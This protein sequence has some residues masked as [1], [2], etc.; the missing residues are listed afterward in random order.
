MQYTFVEWFLYYCYSSG[1][2]FPEF[3]NYKTKRCCTLHY[4]V[5]WPSVENYHI[6]LVIPLWT[7]IQRKKCGYI[8]NPPR[9]APKYFLKSYPAEQN[10]PGKPPMERNE[11]NYYLKI[12]RL[13]S[14]IDFHRQPLVWTPRRNQ[15]SELRNWTRCRNPRSNPSLESLTWNPSEIYGCAVWLLGLKAQ[16]AIRGLIMKNCVGELRMLPNFFHLFWCFFSFSQ[17]V[18]AGD[19]KGGRGGWCSIVLDQVAYSKQRTK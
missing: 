8:W 1:F 14:Q 15:S 11:V 18:V 17:S 3:H 6:F 4:K 5:W 16:A 12:Q 13:V 19:S 10:L 2:P 9:N 7:H